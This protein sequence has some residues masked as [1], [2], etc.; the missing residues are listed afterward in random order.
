MPRSPNLRREIKGVKTN[1]E[2]TEL[3]FKNNSSF[4]TAVSGESARG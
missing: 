4:I 2:S 3:M 1:K